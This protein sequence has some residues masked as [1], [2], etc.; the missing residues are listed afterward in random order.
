MSNQNNTDKQK[1]NIWMDKTLVIQIDGLAARRGVSRASLISE[2]VR[3]HLGG[4]GKAATSEEIS[5]LRAELQT[6]F[7]AIARAI[8][9][10]PIAVQQQAPA[11]PEPPR[12]LT[13]RERITGRTFGE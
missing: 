4:S 7:A 5:A 10:Q 6:S 2:A 1:V 13:L 8:E 12:K 11:L 3:E 9:S